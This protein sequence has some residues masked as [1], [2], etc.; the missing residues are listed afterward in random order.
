MD[1]IT[2]LLEPEVDALENF[3]EDLV[4]RI[5]LLAEKEVNW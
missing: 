4:V 2:V 1:D 3:E 5:Y